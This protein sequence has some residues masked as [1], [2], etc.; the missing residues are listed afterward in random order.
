MTRS[1]A[2]VRDR[3]RRWNERWRPLLP[4]LLAEFVILLGFGSLLPVLPLYVAQ[5]GIDVPTYGLITAAWAIAKLVSEPFFGYIADRTGRPKPQ[6]LVG[7]VLLALF[8][9]LPIVFTSAIALFVLRLLAG[10]SA[11]MYDPAARGIIVDATREGERGEAFGLYSAFQMGGFLVGPVIGALGAHLGGGYVFPFVFTA[12][13]TVAAAGYLLLALPSRSAVATE[14]RAAS[15]PDFGPDIA[16]AGAGDPAAQRSPG[17]RP[18]PRA[19]A[20]VAPLRA[21]LNGPLVAAVVIYF[22][23]SLA[24]GVYEVIW[25]LYMV[26]LGASLEWVGATF[27]LF[28]LGVVVVSPFAGRIVDRVGA[29]RFVVGGSLAIAVAGALYA[30][31]TEPVFPSIVVPFEAVAEGFVTPALFVLVA[32]GSPPGRSSTAQGIFGGAG[33]IALV[34]ASICG[35]VLW[36]RDPAWPF[37][38][39]IVGILVSL[40]IGLAVYASRAGSS[41]GLPGPTLADA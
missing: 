19:E 23:V 1:I 13:V 17:G 27:T 36:A 15:G 14:S 38:F 25:T 40:A 2:A 30:A 29:I 39:F 21:L 16:A 41:V 12:V 4:V 31:S 3:I 24:F 11:G 28:G 26:R 32:A 9:L 33:T 37:W 5:Q 20:T 7:L 6:M 22:G 10:A 8:T 18:N 35:G 34:V